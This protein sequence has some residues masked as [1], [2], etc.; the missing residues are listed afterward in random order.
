[1]A[2][3]WCGI[4]VISVQS[5]WT[6]PKLLGNFMDKILKDIF[7]QNNMENVIADLSSSQKD[8]LLSMCD[9]ISHCILTSPSSH[10]I[11][12]SDNISAND[13]TIIVQLDNFKEEIMNIFNNPYR[14]YRKITDKDSF[15]KSLYIVYPSGRIERFD[16]VLKNILT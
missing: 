14:Y 15:I 7:D 4:S 16:D 13:L 2:T 3:Y 12:K 11:I 8:W 9:K 5:R 10:C 1:M 6:A